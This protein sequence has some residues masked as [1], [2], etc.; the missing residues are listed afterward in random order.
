MRLTPGD[1]AV[2][3]HLVL[4]VG[5]DRFASASD[6]AEHLGLDPTELNDSVEELESRGLADVQRGLG[7]HPYTFRNVAAKALAWLLFEPNQIGFD[8]AE[9]MR[10]VAQC[11]VGHETVGADVLAHDTQLPPERINI[12]ALIL[13]SQGR[14][15]LD[16]FMGTAP[17]HF[18]RVVATRHTRRWVREQSKD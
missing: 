17:Y 2:L 11:V 9:D 15:R 10:I 4:E 5:F 8:P 18:G 7:T 12:A 16:R 14:L 13:E 3:E 6:L 1:L